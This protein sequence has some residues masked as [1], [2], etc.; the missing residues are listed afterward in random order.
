MTSHPGKT[1]IDPGKPVQV[2]IFRPQ[3]QPPERFRNVTLP[4]LRGHRRGEEKKECGDEGEEGTHT[5]A[6]SSLGCR[7]EAALGSVIDALSPPPPFSFALFST[8]DRE[9]PRQDDAPPL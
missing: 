3:R 5:R 4:A 6:L 2:M 8:I 9:G 7:V 1:L